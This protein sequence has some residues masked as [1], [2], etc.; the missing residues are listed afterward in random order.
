MKKLKVSTIGLSYSQSQLGSYVV[1]LE[2]KKSKKRIP[3]IVKANDAQ[4]IALKMESMKVNSPMIHDILKSVT[5]SLS[6]TIT[7]ITIYDIVEGVFHCRI[8]LEDILNQEHKILCSVGDAIAL[9]L[10]FKCD[11]FVNKEVLDATGIQ[12]DEDGQV[13]NNDDNIE[14]KKEVIDIDSLEKMLQNA[15][16]NEEYEVASQLRDKISSLNKQN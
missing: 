2:E 11:L 7:N 1:V 13:I 12:M 15:I 14:E 8:T 3:V 4:Y 5:D 16:E 9:S 6:A 10:S